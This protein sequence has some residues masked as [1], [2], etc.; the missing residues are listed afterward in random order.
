MTLQHPAQQKNKFY[1]LA[2]LFL[3]GRVF[4][5]VTTALFTPN[6]DREANPIVSVLGANWTVVILLQVLLGALILYGLFLY[7]HSVFELPALKQLCF[8]EFISYMNFNTTN[9][10]YKLFYTL[11]KNT[12]YFI[13]HSGFVLTQTLIIS[14]FFVGI[15]TSFLLISE[16][17]RKFYNHGMVYFIY[18]GMIALAI[19]NSYSFYRKSYKAYLQQTE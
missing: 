7:Y 8:T 6:L 19:F 11:P 15:S 10:F 4:D 5:I 16:A 12:S 9:S 2:I 18:A 13:A 14:S 17:Y 3:L 1:L